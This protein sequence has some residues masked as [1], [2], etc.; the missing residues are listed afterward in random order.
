MNRDKNKGRRQSA[1]TNN[2]T[3]SDQAAAPRLLRMSE[4]QSYLGI[5]RSRVYQLLH[6]HGLPQ[7]LRLGAR[8]VF[9]D[10]LEVDQWLTERPRGLSD[11]PAQLA[12]SDKRRRS[13]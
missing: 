8:S 6:E 3:R 11:E 4:L 10:R 7:P 1:I 13:A 2:D 12:E 5:S 9:F